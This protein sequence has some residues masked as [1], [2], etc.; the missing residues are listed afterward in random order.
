MKQFFRISHKYKNVFV[1]SVIQKKSYYDDYFWP[2]EKNLSMLTIVITITTVIIII[3]ILFVQ[4]IVTRDAA[5][6]TTS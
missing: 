4:L 6:F 3:K 1:R 5:H 2:E